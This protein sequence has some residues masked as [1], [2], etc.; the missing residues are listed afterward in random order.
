[1]KN[2]IFRWL[3]NSIELLLRCRVVVVSL[4]VVITCIMGFFAAQIEIKT[5]FGDLLPETH[6]YVQ[7]NNKFKQTFGGSNIVSIMLE[8]EQGDIFT[9]AT[10]EKVQKIT[11]DLQQVEGVDGYQI[12][13]LASR[14]LREVRASTMGI[15]SYPLMW[16]DLPSDDAEIQVLKD[17]VL[18][19]AMV[20]GPYV[21]RD[22]KA[23]LITADFED[24]DVDYLKAYQQINAIV[25]QVRGQ[26]VSVRM[27]GEPILYGLVNHFLSETLYIFL[28]TFVTMILLLLLITRTWYGTLLPLVSGFLS[29]VWALGIAN[30]MGFNLDPLVIVVAF[31]ITA[32]ALSTSVQLISRYEYALQTGATDSRTA[33]RE[34][35]A[36]LFKPGMLAVLTGAFCV[37]VVSMTPIPLLVKI[38]YIGTVWLFSTLITALLL[39]PVLLSW[40]GGQR[41]VLHPVDVTPLFNW[42]L[43]LCARIV[44]SR[45]RFVV[46]IGAA[47]VFVVSGMYAMNIKIG[48]ANPG[49]PIL[50]PDSTYNMAAKS[51]NKKFQGSDRMFVVVAGKEE[52]ALKEPSVLKSME[53]FQKY[54]EAQPEIGGSLSI[55]D[56]LPGV[57]RVLREGNVRY[58][59]LGES[60]NENGELTYMFVSGTDPGDMERFADPQMENGSVTLFFRDHQGDTIRTA[61]A[62]AKEYIARNVIPEADFL[63]AG[64]LVGVLGAVNEVILAGQIESIAYALLVVIVICMLGYRSTMAG[65]FFMIPVL[66]SNTLTFS[67]MAWQNI[68][69]SINTLPVVALGIGFGVDYSIYIVDGIREELHRHNDIERAITNAIATAGRAVLVTALTLVVS[70]ILWSY[71]SLRLQAEMG[72]LIAIWLFISA[73]SAMFLMPSMV[74]VFRPKFIVGSK[75]HPIKEELPPTLSHTERK[76]RWLARADV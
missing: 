4:V 3:G 58:Q 12:V 36:H 23:T 74:A 69:M 40:C 55:A 13:S 45:L 19:N 64:G 66:L 39:T 68:G 49:S 53:R 7:I 35:L 33:A 72:V 34:S 60:K 57:N 1:M 30:L 27:V 24:G 2:T 31:L 51:I 9:M 71:S 41:R 75:V 5:V 47:V 20:Y 76:K 44:T 46:I 11:Q 18:N 67:F 29:A 70:V 62:R 43:A 32:N 8:V 6:P 50:W 48:D 14:K 22:L 21:S 61:I 17:A 10:L 37:L 54:M 52:G 25:E 63:L 26:G 65:V 59:Q 73:T 28:V 42:I 15:E 38:S 16:P 56:I